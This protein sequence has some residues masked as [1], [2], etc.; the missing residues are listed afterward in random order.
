MRIYDVLNSNVTN[1]AIRVGDVIPL[2][3]KQVTISVYTYVTETDKD[4]RNHNKTILTKIDNS[5]TQEVIDV[6]ASDNDFNIYV[7]KITANQIYSILTQY[8]FPKYNINP[9][10]N[11]I[12]RFINGLHS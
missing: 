10:I 8:T 5:L 11:T 12:K 7:L 1:I 2:L 6:V 3:D 9:F 4:N